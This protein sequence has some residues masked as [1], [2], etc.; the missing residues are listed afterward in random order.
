MIFVIVR[1]SYPF[2]ASSVTIHAFGVASRIIV[3][4]FGE[5]GGDDAALQAK[6]R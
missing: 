4:I 5:A 6:E 2:V 1:H 3:P